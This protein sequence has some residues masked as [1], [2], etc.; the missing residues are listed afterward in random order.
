M[1]EEDIRRPKRNALKQFFVL[2]R[3]SPKH[4]EMRGYTF[5]HFFL[6]HGR[7]DDDR[8]GRERLFA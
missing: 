5:I 2:G 3:H 4:F 1:V 6:L 8:A 7:P